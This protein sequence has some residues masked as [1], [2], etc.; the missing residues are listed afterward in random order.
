MKK[1]ICIVLV[2]SL[3]FLG[4]SFA[5]KNEY[6]AMYDSASKYF[7]VK[8][9]Q[10]AL[11]VFL[12]MI[13]AEPDNANTAYHI[14]ICYNHMPLDKHM[15]IPYLEKATRSVSKDYKNGID[16]KNAP[17]NAYYYLGQAY[18]INYELEKAISTTEKYKTFLD[19]KTQSTEI[20]NADRQ[21]TMC[22]V[23]REMIKDPVPIK[24]VN[25]G[26]NIN[27]KYPEYA[28][29]VD[30]DSKT[31]VFTARRNTNVGGY[32][33]PNGYYFEDLYISTKDNNDKWRKAKNM[34]PPINSDD[35]EA[36][37][38]LSADK[39]QLF[40]YIDDK[41]D[42]NIYVSNAEKNEWSA[43]VKLPA[44]IN[45]KAWEA[46]A[47][48]S[49]DGKVLYFTSNRK[50][51]FGEMDIYKCD[52]KPNGKWG[53]AKNLGEVINTP[54][55]EDGPFILSDSTLYFCSEGH[56]TMGGYDIFFSKMKKDGSW[57]TPE[58][59]GYPINT[60]SNDMFYTPVDSLGG[61]FA[62]VRK[63]G[64]GDLD[65]YKLSIYKLKIRGVAFDKQTKEKIPEAIVTL[66]NDKKEVVDQVIAD[67][68]GVFTFLAD[69][70]TNYNIKG[71]KENYIA[72]YNS[73]STFKIKITKEVTADVLLDRPQF[74]L[75]VQITDAKTNQLL[76]DVGITLKD[77]KSG[78]I[79]D[80]TTN[81]NGEIN[82]Y[83]VDSKINDS[84]RYSLVITK[85]G[86]VPKNVDY[87][88]LITEPGEIL[89]KETIGKLEVGVD[90]AKLIQIKPIFFDLDKYN[91][92]PDAAI[93]LD[94]IVAILKKYPSI[95]IELGSHTDCRASF[96]YNNRLS[97]NRAK[98][99][100]A[101][102][103][104]QGISSNRITWKGY[105]ETQ[106]ITDC[107]CEGKIQSGCSEAQHQLNRRTEFKITGFAEGIGNVSIVSEEIE[108]VEIV[109]QRTEF[110]GMDTRM[111]AETLKGL[112]YRVQFMSVT[113]EL[114]VTA[115]FFMGLQNISVY[116]HKGLY[117]YTWG[118][119][120]NKAEAQELQ[121]LL[122][123]KGFK[124][125]FIVP[126]LDN[127]RITM[128]EAER[129]EKK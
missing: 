7:Q 101:Y 116:K 31:L 95:E 110:V 107:P 83:L 79:E 42:G 44:P 46:H 47:S 74:S 19:E 129:L 119:T 112:V 89:I 117:K 94:K 59:M 73:V 45:T 93:E 78:D 2:T 96:E 10:M 17:E 15:A 34:G 4:H 97:E 60:T 118:E 24:V 29:A 109:G 71:Q 27:T 88:Y 92:R 98:S 85:E 48:L 33:E 6:K 40:I 113:E 127:K 84:L 37:I 111:T 63:E 39:K 1:I 86:Y 32:M 104:S 13:L 53:E 103:V 50:G 69:Y 55:N 49:P 102:I 123:E 87:K 52:K 108:K 100:A 91:I 75:K 25:L 54:Y 77:L 21:I 76:P 8:N 12:R 68:N 30:F 16:E 106:L 67:T 36:S 90:L 20:R 9:Y 62:S 3:F 22:N 65:I 99:T 121:K 82:K 58:N 122:M 66:M 64:F 56:N 28:P 41:G 43:P 26:E 11:P 114:P 81:E 38:S 126:F 105:G 14:G 51:G 18:L 120:T 124:G 70:N 128:E 125:A 80:L 57:S 115:S 61:Y 23:A 72:G 5:Q 35:H